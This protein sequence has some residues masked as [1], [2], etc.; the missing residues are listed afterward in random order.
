MRSVS[1]LPSRKSGPWMVRMSSW[2]PK[3]NVWVRPSITGPSTCAAVAAARMAS[4]SRSAVAQVGG[5]V[6]PPSGPSRRMT[7]WKWTAPRFWYSA[8]LAKET[9]ACW[10]KARWV[11]PARRG[12]LAAEVDREAAPQGSG[13]GVPEDGGFVVVGGRVEWS[14]QGGVLRVV[15]R[16]AAA[17]APVGGAVVDGAEA[18]GGEGGEDA[19]V[20]G[21][22]FAG[23]FAAAESGGD[24]VVGVAAVGLGAGGAAGGAAVAAADQE[25]T[26]GQLGGVETVQG[27]ADLAGGG[28]DLVFGAVSGQA[29]GVGAAAEGGE[30]ACEGGQ[31]ACC[32]EVGEFRQWGRGGAGDDGALLRRLSGRKGAAAGA[33][34]AWR[35]RG[36]P[37]SALSGDAGN[38]AGSAGPR[39]SRPRRWRRRRRRSGAR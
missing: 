26:G 21:D 15:T 6:L 13:V 32:G 17:V 31:G 28:V 24:Q 30:L 36:R 8:T 25:V 4:V 33:V 39:R 10:W 37:G 27:R 3:A 2:G 5:G 11:S 34:D 20:C 1:A 19:G 29:D 9:R 12:D 35:Y 22:L 23:A 16:A 38:A 14:A 18:R 7:A